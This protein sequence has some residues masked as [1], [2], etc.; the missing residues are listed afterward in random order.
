MV[1]QCS[2]LTIKAKNSQEITHIHCAPVGSLGAV[3]FVELGY[4]LIPSAT[5]NLSLFSLLSTDRTDGVSNSTSGV[6]E[7]FSAVLVLA[8]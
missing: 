8:G 4:L 2:L 1:V 5:A 6:Y 7:A 3:S